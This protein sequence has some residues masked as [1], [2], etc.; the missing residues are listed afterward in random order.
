M[1]AVL[2]VISDTSHMQASEL[3]HKNIQC[4]LWKK[5]PHPPF[6]RNPFYPLYPSKHNNHNITDI[7]DMHRIVYT[8]LTQFLNI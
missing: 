3:K 2:G 1:Q 5:G 8:P 7:A 6:H 4:R